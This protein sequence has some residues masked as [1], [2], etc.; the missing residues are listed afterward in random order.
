[1]IPTPEEMG[2]VHFVGVGGTG[3]SGIAE[4]L[5][6]L[7]YSVQGS[8]LDESPRLK[9]LRRLGVRAMIGHD[10]ANLGDARAVVTS[11][12]IPVD[13][14]ELSA[15]RVRGLP[16]VRRAE[17]LAELMRF[18][19][20]IAVS[21]THGKTT[22]TSMAAA[23]LD[24]AGLSPT[25]INGGVIRSYGSTARLGGGDWMVVEADES[26]GSF[27]HLPP[28]IAVVTSIDPEHMDHY[29]DQAALESAFASFALSV[30]FYGSVVYCVDH[31]VA[32]RVAES[33][34]GRRL[35]SY[36]TDESADVRAV[37][38][39]HA[40]GGTEFNIAV[41]G[42]DSSRRVI[43]GLHLPMPGRH[44]VLNA[45]AAVA[46]GMEAGVEDWVFPAA[47]AE[48]RGV[49]RR[50]TRIGIADGVEVVDDYAHHPAE[51]AATIEAAREVCDGKII[52]VH[53]PHRYSRL[54]SLFEE[55]CSC[56]DGAD[57]VVIT[58]IYAAG[59]A[60][61]KGWH[62]KL[63]V[64][65]IR[66]HGHPQVEALSAPDALPD[67]VRRLAGPGDIVLCMGAGSITHWAKSLPEKLAT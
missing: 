57:V 60:P 7:G 11:S 9:E 49:G 33:I 54:S 58:E 56:F 46:A 62:Y 39:N 66:D 38:L 52:A 2:P 45:T 67:M 8:D 12:A 20:N 40:N 36:G 29:A 48:Y 26:D 37:S 55:F 18:K 35:V 1:M 64:D 5:H 63:L 15:A 22:T 31:P 61:R 34:V 65:G 4:V 23:V 13:N 51:I 16:V 41:R 24:R 25:V 14:P 10:A 47:L 28:T 6:N 32:R 30:P 3:M 21:G 27:L 50:F 43:K 59:E 42:A 19:R 17:M 53:Q 44:N